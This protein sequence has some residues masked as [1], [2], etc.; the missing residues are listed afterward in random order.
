MTEP[1]MA[2]KGSYYL[3]LEPGE[4]WWC[5]CGRAKTQPFC[6]GS[7]TDTGLEPIPFTVTERQTVDLCGCKHSK[8][9]PFCDGTHKQLK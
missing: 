5:S 6:D 4:Y 9:C 1:V 2:K 3:E 7:H 8:T